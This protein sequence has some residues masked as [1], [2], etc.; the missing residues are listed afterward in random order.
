MSSVNVYK[1][2]KNEGINKIIIIKNIINKIIKLLKYIQFIFII[3]CIYKYLVNR[4]LLSVLHK[5]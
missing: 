4:F 2:L 5:I 1:F 3:V